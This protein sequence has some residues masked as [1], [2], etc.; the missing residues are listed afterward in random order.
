M[1]ERIVKP[2]PKCGQPLEIKKNRETG[3]EFF[4]CSAWRETGCAH[5]EPL[6][7]TIKLRRQG[8]QDMFGDEL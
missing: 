7:E 5:T 6:P 3:H 8:V 4:G 2:C 1:K